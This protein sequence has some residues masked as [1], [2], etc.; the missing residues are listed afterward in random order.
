[1]PVYTPGEGKSS[2]MPVFRNI[3]AISSLTVPIEFIY[4]REN[5]KVFKSTALVFLCTA[6]AFAVTAGFSSVKVPI[7]INQP[8]FV[9]DEHIDVPILTAS[10][11]PLSGIRLEGSFGFR[12][13]TEKDDRSYSDDIDSRTEVF[14]L[15]SFYTLL[16][17]NNAEFS[18]GVRFLHS[19]TTIE[20]EGSELLKSTMNNYGPSVRMDFSI[21]GLEEI[22]FYSQWGVDYSQEETIYYYEGEEEEKHE[23][24]G[25]K[26]SGP[27][28]ILSGIY[29][30]F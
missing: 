11:E 25:W 15:S 2:E 27:D 14:G 18:A 24:D 6:A 1:M 16:N 26:T 13:H 22:G 3:N 5:F 9:W 23:Q 4:R 28:Y 19:S 12:A 20:E 8:Y 17:R 29:Y 7:D 30:S 21:P 10:V